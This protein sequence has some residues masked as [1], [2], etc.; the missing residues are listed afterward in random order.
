MSLLIDQAASP[1]AKRMDL[2][3]GPEKPLGIAESSSCFGCAPRG[4]DQRSGK[5]QKYAIHARRY[6]GRNSGRWKGRP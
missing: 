5:A 2:T 3:E 6:A 4:A 1:A